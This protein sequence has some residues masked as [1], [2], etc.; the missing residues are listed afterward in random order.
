MLKSNF[1]LENDVVAFMCF[2]SL[3]Y[4]KLQVLD[5]N[6]IECLKKKPLTSSV[7]LA[8]GADNRN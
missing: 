6:A 2:D 3:S 7:S 5:E 4:R 8:I 1:F